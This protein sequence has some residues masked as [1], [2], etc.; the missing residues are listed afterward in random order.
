[1]ILQYIKDDAISSF[2]LCAFGG[3]KRSGAYTISS[4]SITGAPC[5][6]HEDRR[7][8]KTAAQI[9]HLFHFFPHQLGDCSVPGLKVFLS[10]FA[11]ISSGVTFSRKSENFVIYC[12][13]P[14]TV[15][16][17]ESMPA[18]PELVAIFLKMSAFSWFFAFSSSSGFD[19]L[20]F[21]VYPVLYKLSLPILR[22][23]VARQVQRIRQ[24]D[25]DI[26]R[27][28]IRLPYLRPRPYL[29]QPMP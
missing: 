5:H 10:R 1:V 28:E 15:S 25:W 12:Q 27:L 16:K 8:I 4:G 13:L 7:T 9:M 19:G 21:S 23:C 3:S 22:R 20:F 11:M 18:R 6:A 14:A 17:Y 24:K 29:F 26:W 2:T